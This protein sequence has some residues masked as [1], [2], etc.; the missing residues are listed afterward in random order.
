V[1]GLPSLLVVWTYATT[2]SPRIDG[3]PPRSRFSPAAIASARR[4]RGV[5][6]D[7]R[8]VA[9]VARAYCELVQH[10]HPE[11][12]DELCRLLDKRGVDYAPSGV[13]ELLAKARERGLLTDAPPG[14]AG[15]MLTEKALQVLA[16]KP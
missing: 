8:F 7:D 15:G 6:R 13:R 12:I 5:R 4:P 2:S 14:R 16:E 11:V 3:K 1:I 9:E 10:G